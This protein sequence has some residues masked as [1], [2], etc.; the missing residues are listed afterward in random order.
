MSTIYLKEE[1]RKE[2][3]IDKAIDLFVP[4]ACD[5]LKNNLRNHIKVRHKEIQCA[6][7]S[8]MVKDVMEILGI[9]DAKPNKIVIITT[10]FNIK[11]FPLPTL[12]K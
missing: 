9:Y 1:Q 3:A 5:R 11:E 2:Q 12:N 8:P 4:N 6:V 7:L 10:N